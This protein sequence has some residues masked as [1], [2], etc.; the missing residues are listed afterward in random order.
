MDDEYQLCLRR[1]MENIPKFRKNSE[2]TRHF[3]IQIVIINGTKA[4]RIM[5][6]RISY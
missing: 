4:K 1:L 6:Q 2:K 3:R 5:P